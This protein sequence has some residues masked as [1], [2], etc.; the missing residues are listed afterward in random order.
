[1]YVWKKERKSGTLVG[2][3]NYMQR[4]SVLSSHKEYFGGNKVMNRGIAFLKKFKI[5]EHFWNQIPCEINIC[6]F[7]PSHTHNEKLGVSLEFAQ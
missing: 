6:I 3:L 5:I 7:I 4:S 1:M 2:F